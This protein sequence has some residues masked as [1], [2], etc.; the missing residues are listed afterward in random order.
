M[1]REPTDIGGLRTDGWTYVKKK[2][3][4]GRLLTSGPTSQIRGKTGDLADKRF[5]SGPS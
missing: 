5:I 1:K 2:P 4:P 3:N